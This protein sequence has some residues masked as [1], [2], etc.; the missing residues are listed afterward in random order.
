MVVV[1]AGAQSCWLP[2]RRS[3]VAG[4]VWRPGRPG[5]SFSDVRLLVLDGT[6]RQRRRRV[7]QRWSWRTG[8]ELRSV[9]VR[10][11]CMSVLLLPALL[12]GLA[13]RR[14]CL[15]R[16]PKCPPLTTRW[17]LRSGSGSFLLLRRPRVSPFQVGSGDSWQL[18]GRTLSFGMCGPRKC[19]PRSL[20][21]RRCLPWLSVR[22]GRVQPRGLARGRGCLLWLWCRVSSGWWPKR[23]ETGTPVVSASPTHAGGPK[24]QVLPY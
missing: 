18:S 4:D 5:R 7:R 22:A 1:A 11:L 14:R 6:H 17:A 9:L 15:L 3:W 12:C 24:R 19:L 10:A 13:G 23:F 2:S 21:R 20:L 8:N 16:G